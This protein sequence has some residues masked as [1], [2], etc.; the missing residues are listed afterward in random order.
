MKYL[1]IFLI[2]FSGF[3]FSQKTIH[4]F[5]ALCDNKYQGIVPVGAKIGNGQDPKNNLYWGC[6]YGVKN[7]F[8]VKSPQW[9][10]VKTI[11]NPKTH[12]L[13]RCIFKYATQNTYLV[14]DA[15]DGQ[16]IKETTMDFFSA[17]SGNLKDSAQLDSTKYLQ[18]GGNSKLVCYIGHDGLMNFELDSVAYH[19]DKITRRA[20]ILACISRS[21]FKDGLRS[22]GATPL[23]WT[24]GLM[25]PEAYTLEAAVNG[26][27]EGKKD[28]DIREMAAQAFSKY[29][30]KCSIKASRNLLVTG[31]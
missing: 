25:A 13:E 20:I 1:L 3:L 23:L 30:K 6:G 8:K 5:V 12:I 16:Y 28:A 7:F 27:L 14:A 19:S 10:L 11:L 22:A 9:K 17:V 2:L 4:V 21:Y 29:Q 15:Y 31:W 24:T 18:I 26:W